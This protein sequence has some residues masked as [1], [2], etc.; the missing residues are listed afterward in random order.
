MAHMSIIQ[1]NEEDGDVLGLHHQ[2]VGEIDDEQLFSSNKEESELFEDEEELAKA[3][4]AILAIVNEEEDGSLSMAVISP[5]D[6]EAN[7]EENQALVDEIDWGAN[8]SIEP[9]IPR[10]RDHEGFDQ[11]LHGGETNA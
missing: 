5:V 6:G 4:D 10:S 2:F 9:C 1:P 11:R 8:A 7:D 3:A